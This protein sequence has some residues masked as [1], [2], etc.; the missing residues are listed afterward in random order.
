MLSE[1]LMKE[2]STA[3]NERLAHLRKEIHTELIKSDNQQYIE[4]AGKVHDRE[5]ESVADLLVDLNLADIDRHTNEI[6]DIEMA[7]SRIKDG[8][9]GTCS[10]CNGLIETN[11]LQAYPAANRCFAC[12]ALYEKTHTQPGHSSL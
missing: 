4:L 12:Q 6:R 7:L 9:Y 2:I 1:P 8:S 11:R 5:E 3:L 10:D